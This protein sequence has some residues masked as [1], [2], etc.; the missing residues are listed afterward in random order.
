MFN[1]LTFNNHWFPH[2]SLQHSFY[3][4]NYTLC[5][6]IVFNASLRRQS[7]NKGGEMFSY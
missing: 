6:T 3:E 7:D 2:T 4:N 5:K 1:N